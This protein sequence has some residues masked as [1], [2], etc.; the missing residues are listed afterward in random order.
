MY[1]THLSPL[2]AT[3]V[4]DSDLIARLASDAFYRNTPIVQEKLLLSKNEQTFSGLLGHELTQYP[5]LQ[6]DGGTNPQSGQV[7]LELKG[8]DYIKTDRNGQEKRTPNFHD[9]TI[10]NP[11]A[12]IEVIIENKVWY[13]FDGAKGAD[14]GKP[15]PGIAR[16]LKADIAKIKQTLD[17]SPT[18]KRGFILLNIVT[19]SDPSLIPATYR[20]EHEKAWDRS[21]RSPAIYREDGLR[22]I[23]K[24]VENFDKDLR[25]I[26]VMES[27]NSDSLGALDVICAEVRID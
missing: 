9:I 2:T 10:V 17:G 23:R 22:G 20:R 21:M 18:L 12:E 4:L 13:H 14:R 8:K 5:T 15:E 27:R 3:T 24:V 7:L 26:R 6:L 11:D 16:Q 1:M 25:G 19:P